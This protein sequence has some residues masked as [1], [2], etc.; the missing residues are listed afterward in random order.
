MNETDLK[1]YGGYADLLEYSQGRILSEINQILGRL[2]QDEEHTPAEHIRSRIKSAQ[3]V[4][5]KLK[6]RGFPG[7]AKTSLAELSDVIGIRV[8]THFIGDIYAILAQLK[9]SGQ[10]EVI[11]IKDY[12]SNPKQNGYRSLHVILRIPVNHPDFVFITAEIQLRTIAMD[13]WASLEHQMKYKK[14]VQNAELITSELKRCA[15]EMA[16]TDLTMQTIR[17]LIQAQ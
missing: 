14:I 8:V 5:E 1:Y 10:W 11:Q 16:S 2:T 17:E 3:S 13:C 15:D 12:I 6:K 9:S 4:R 7:D